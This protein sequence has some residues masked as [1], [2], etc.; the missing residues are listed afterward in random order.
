MSATKRRYEFTDAEANQLFAYLNEQERTDW[1][2]GVKNH[3][4]ARH[5]RIRMEL[6]R[7]VLPPTAPE[8]QP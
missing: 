8:K 2:Y 5:K 3:F 7:H 1:Y 4:Y 6:M